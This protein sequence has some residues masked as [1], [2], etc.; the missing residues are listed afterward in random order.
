MRHNDLH[1]MRHDIQAGSDSTASEG[2][3][4]GNPPVKTPPQPNKVC[5]TL[6]ILAKIL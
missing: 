5:M 4:S 3:G 6:M 1:D 2:I